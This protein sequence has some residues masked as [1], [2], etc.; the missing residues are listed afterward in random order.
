MS[1]PERAREPRVVTIR[2][3]IL[4]PLLSFLLLLAFA[5]GAAADMRLP[6]SPIGQPPVIRTQVVRHVVA[7]ADKRAEVRVRIAPTPQPSGRCGG[8]LPPC[9]VM[10]RESRGNPRAFNPT[11]CYHADDGSSGCYG[12]WQC[13][14]RTCDGTGTEEEQDAEARRV[15]ANGAG[16]SH[17]AAC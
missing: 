3:L 6:S 12:K 7:N 2:L 4:V 17:W 1:T 13:D 8:D 9:W 10:M 16:C 5:A 15:W 11:G 14:P